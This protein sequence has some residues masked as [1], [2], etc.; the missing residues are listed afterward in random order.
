VF[1][2]REDIIRRC[3]SLISKALI[4]NAVVALLPPI[5]LLVMDRI[6]LVA[7]V[8]FAFSVVS[9]IML[10]VLRRS[11]EDYSL[12]TAYRLAPI[13]AFTGFIGGAVIV[14]VIV[15]KV[16]GMLADFLASRRGASR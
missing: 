12:G 9:I 6:D 15:L 14:G 16:R 3:S 7:L 1:I 2:R 4:I 11:I 13:A 5:Y 10:Y 8:V